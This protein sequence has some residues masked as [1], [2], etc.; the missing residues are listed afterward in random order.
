MALA[1]LA[2]N[3]IRESVAL[4]SCLDAGGSYDYA[5]ARCDHERNH[6]ASPFAER[7][8][9]WLLGTGIA[10][11]LFSAGAAISARRT[12]SVRSVGGPYGPST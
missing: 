7:P 11:L 9:A 6:T 12:Q 3:A 8:R 2:V 1:P 10:V 5:A 4:D